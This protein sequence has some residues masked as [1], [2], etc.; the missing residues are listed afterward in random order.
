MPSKFS[1]ALYLGVRDISFLRARGAKIPESAQAVL[2]NLFALLQQCIRAPNYSFA[3]LAW[4]WFCHINFRCDIWA[5]QRSMAI[6]EYYSK[7]SAVKKTVLREKIFK[8]L[9]HDGKD[10][11]YSRHSKQHCGKGSCHKSALSCCIFITAFFA[12]TDHH[13][14]EQNRETE[15]HSSHNIRCSKTRLIRHNML[16]IQETFKS[17]KS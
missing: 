12:D 4:D 16:R 15:N 5:Q 3:A 7:R 10:E 14:F 13:K 9:L 8:N 1:A 6:Y 2:Q 11:A 17:D